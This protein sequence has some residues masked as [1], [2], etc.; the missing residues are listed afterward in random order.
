MKSVC[1]QYLLAIQRLKAAGKTLRR[2]V[3]LTYV[4]DEEIGGTDAMGKFAP[5]EAFTKLNAGLV[6]DEGIAN[7]GNPYTVFYGERTPWWIIVKA[8]GATGHGSRFIQG[9]AV[10]KLLSV[11]DKAMKF[12]AEQEMMV[13]FKG[14]GCAH[15]QAKKLGDVTTLNLTMLQA[16]VS[17]DGGQTYAL[18]VIP[19]QCEAGFD[20]RIPPSVPTEDIKAKLTEWCTEEG[21][22]WDFAPWTSPLHSHHVTSTNSEDNFW[23]GHFEGA[24]KALELE[25]ELEVFPAATDS[26]FVRQLG[27]PAL[28]FSPMNHTEVLLHDHNECLHEKV[29]LRGV[30]LY[31]SIVSELANAPLNPQEMESSQAKK[32]K[33]M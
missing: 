18:N 7:P 17:L 13:G 24:C 4:P 10:S 29:F 8:E 14:I 2:T 20:I 3:H 28:G 23:W 21:L 31:E 5:S 22:T 16:G 30:E 1:V 25:L 33:V 6:L 12:R 26:R 11:A 9:T 15:C 19:N 32:V 27:I